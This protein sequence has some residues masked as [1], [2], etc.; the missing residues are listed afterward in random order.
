[1]NTLQLLLSNQIYLCFFA[2]CMAACA[3][4]IVI[5]HRKIMRK[6]L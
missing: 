4:A 5:V 2:L 1:M 6:L 3:I